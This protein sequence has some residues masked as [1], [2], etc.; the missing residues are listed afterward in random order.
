MDGLLVCFEGLDGAGKRTQAK[1]LEESLGKSGIGTAFYSYPDYSSVYGK[2][3]EDFLRKR[4]DMNV[5]EL[6]MLFLADMVKDSGRVRDDLESGKVV[7]MDRYFLS[8]VA[9]QGAVGPNYERMKAVEDAVGLPKPDMVFYL[10][11]TA[12]TSLERK[13]LQKGALDKHEGDKAYLEKVAGFYEMLIKE[14]YGAKEWVRID[15]TQ[16]KDS[17]HEKAAAMVR[18]AIGR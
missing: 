8:T 7:I 12:E 6:F 9:Y 18:K 13:N 3:I 10:D 11:I 1:M 4:I 14:K 2:R 15:G 17:I 5:D 16:P